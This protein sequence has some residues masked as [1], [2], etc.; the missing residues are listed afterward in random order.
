MVLLRF[1]LVGAANEGVQND[2]VNRHY[3][4]EWREHESE[5]LLIHGWILILGSDSGIH[6]ILLAARVTVGTADIGI[7]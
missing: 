6:P 5:G 3:L 4:G 7:A 1:D 2:V